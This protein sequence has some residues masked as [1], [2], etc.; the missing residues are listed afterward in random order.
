MKRAWTI[1]KKLIVSFLGVATITLLLGGV[2][3]YGAIESGKAIQETAEV[4]LP[5]VANLMIIK[6]AATAIKTA[7]RT[8]LDLSL[9]PNER[10]TQYQR[11]QEARDRYTKAWDIFE[12]LPKSPQEAELWQKLGVAWEGWRKE[13]NAFIK[14]AEGFDQ[15]GVQDPSGV[16]ADMEKF[17]GDHYGLVT[18]SLV[19]VGAKDAFEGGEDHTQCALGR[20]MADF[21]TQNPEILA[22][23]REIDDPH[24]KFHAAVRQ[25]KELIRQGD[26]EAAGELASKDIVGGSA[27]VSQHIDR[28]IAQGRRAN[29]IGENSRTQALTACRRA[30]R[31][32]EALL[33][34]LVEVAMAASNE[35]ATQATNQAAF[36]KTV[37]II[38]VAIGVAAAVALGI[39]ISRSLNKTLT[40]IAN[41]LGT[42][43]DEVNDAAAQVSS[44]SQQLAEGASE[45]A[46][47]LEEIGRAHV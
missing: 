2:G 14:D 26:V 12:N 36:L 4:Q 10:K 39:V 21:R 17:R 40:R 44:A 34:Q 45:Q 19:A 15:I 3:Y 25:M 29:E 38:A 28:L 31:E 47:S 1:G 6:E 18:K 8:L 37:S 22:I 16:R 27:I 9:E 30:E 43:A 32:V 13:N 35:T 33:N 7:Q 23:L 46:S 5:S 24:R 41:A 11:I 20:W 42:G